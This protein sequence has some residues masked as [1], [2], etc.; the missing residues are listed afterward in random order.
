MNTGITKAIKH[1]GGRV[2]LANALGIKF[3]TIQVWEKSK[4]GVPPI[5]RCVQI[6]K[7]TNGAVTRK[8]L[9]PNDWHEIWV[10]LID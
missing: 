4:A 6:E 2:A 3:Q 8:D 9:R 1:F 10:E 7:L 5:K